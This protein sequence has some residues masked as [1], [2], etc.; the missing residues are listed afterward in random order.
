MGIWNFVLRLPRKRQ[1]PTRLLK[2]RILVIE[3]DPSNS[4]MLQ[5]AIEQETPYHVLVAATGTEALHALQKARPDLVLLDYTL[6]DMNGLQVYER[7]RAIPGCETVPVVLV[8]ASKP[9]TT[10]ETAQL[11][12]LEKPFDLDTLFETLHFHLAS[13]EIGDHHPDLW[14]PERRL[15]HRLS[16]SLLIG[17]R[18]DI[19]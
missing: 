15:P 8:T 4:Q 1:T 16:K 18:T 3:D 11:P 17:K 6:P 19:L 14:R 13:V 2:K 5:L 7:L 10:E 9:Q 12:R